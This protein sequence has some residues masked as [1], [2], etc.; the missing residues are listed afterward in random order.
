MFILNYST[1]ILPKT[2]PALVRRALVKFLNV[3]N[4]CKDPWFE[5]YDSSS[6]KDV[7]RKHRGDIEIESKF[8]LGPRLKIPSNINEL[9][10]IFNFKRSFLDF[11][12]NKYENPS[13][14][15]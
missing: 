5:I 8:C 7:K 1:R 12:M 3:T 13:D 14:I 9:L 2:N 10:K 4:I 15:L 6:I 11:L